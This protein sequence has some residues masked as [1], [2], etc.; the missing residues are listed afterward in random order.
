MIKKKKT[1]TKAKKTAIGSGTQ[2]IQRAPYQIPPNKSTD[3]RKSSKVIA[4]TDT[5]SFIPETA[6]T[7]LQKCAWCRF[8]A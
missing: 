8:P 2:S 1:A 4:D 6:D 7:F 3:K 5:G